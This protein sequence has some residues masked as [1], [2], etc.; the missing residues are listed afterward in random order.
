[1]E[2]TLG[3]QRPFSFRETVTLMSQNFLDDPRGRESGRLAFAAEQL[4]RTDRSA[5]RQNYAR[6]AALES[7]LLAEVPRTQRRIFSALAVSAVALWFKAGESTRVI[8]LAAQLLNDADSLTADARSE[9]RGMHDDC[10]LV[11]GGT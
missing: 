2:G 3:P 9:I 8:E 4:L 5:A 1:M 7:E 10:L 11:F 6:A